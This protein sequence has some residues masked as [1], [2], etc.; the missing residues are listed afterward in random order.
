L[1]YVASSVF[2]LVPE[3]F[4]NE[5]MINIYNRIINNEYINLRTE[6]IQKDLF[7]VI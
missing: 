7:N 6:N 1:E 3:Y 4:S 5:E 2:R